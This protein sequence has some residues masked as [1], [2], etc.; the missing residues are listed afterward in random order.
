MNVTKISK[1]FDERVAE[2]LGIFLRSES[3]KNYV[4]KCVNEKST[5]IEYEENGKSIHLTM[6]GDKFYIVV[7]HARDNMIITIM[8]PASR[9]RRE[10]M[11]AFEKTHSKDLSDPD[12][13]NYHNWRADIIERSG[14]FNTIPKV[15]SGSGKPYGPRYVLLWGGEERLAVWDGKNW[16]DVNQVELDDFLIWG[17]KSFEDYENWNRHQK[18]QKNKGDSYPLATS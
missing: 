1:H 10:G 15:K 6:I 13:L 12:I 4:L 5:F 9:I 2:R 14:W 16:T 3:E 11:I 7:V 17:W 18:N 8:H